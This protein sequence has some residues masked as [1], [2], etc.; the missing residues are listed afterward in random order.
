MQYCFGF[1]DTYSRLK[2]ERN[3]LDFDDLEHFTLRLAL[4]P[5]ISQEIKNKFDEIMVDE[6]Q[7]TNGVQEAIFKAISKGDN[8]FMV[9]DVKQSIYGFRNAQPSIFTAKSKDYK[10]NPDAGN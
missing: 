2:R 6:Y 5:E 4:D 9:G 8:L 7:D 1:S 3:L 10:S